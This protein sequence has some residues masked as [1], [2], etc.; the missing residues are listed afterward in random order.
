[1]E[2][3]YEETGTQ[4]AP[5]IVFLHGI[6]AGSWMWWNQI[7]EFQDYRCI[8]VD[9]PGHGNS[10][11]VPWVSL[12]DT[13]RKIIQLIEENFP[14]E[15]VHVVGLSLGGNVVMELILKYSGLFE[16]AF[17]SGI[18][19]RPAIN[20][21]TAKIQV[22]FYEKMKNNP[23]AVERLAEERYH[24]DEE[25]Q[26]QF[27]RDLDKMSMETYRTIIE[28]VLRFRL[29]DSFRTVEVPLMVTAG[30]EESKRIKESVYEIPK[31]MPKAAGKLIPDADHGWNVSLSERFNEECRNWIE[32]HS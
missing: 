13:S 21:L 28:E 8:N 7:E 23:K 26:I 20:W 3:Y 15:K 9:L 4:D 27:K 16:S 29:N 32:G 5:V 1:M 11:D 2:L 10:V 19:V 25:R 22:Y 6:G 14:G 24:L 31:M 30:R 12:E 17:I 18:T